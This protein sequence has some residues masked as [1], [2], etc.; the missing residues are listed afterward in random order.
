MNRKNEINNKINEFQKVPLFPNECK[1][2]YMKVDDFKKNQ[3]FCF[4]ITNNIYA[5]GS[6]V[7][8][9]LT[10]FE[11]EWYKGA[12]VIEIY[13]Y[14]TEA[15]QVDVFKKC[16]KELLFP[17]VITK[18]SFF[19][20]GIL[21]PLEYEYSSTTKYGFYKRKFNVKTEKYEKLKDIYSEY[22]LRVK[23]KKDYISLFAITTNIGLFHE[24]Y[25][26]INFQN[27]LIVSGKDMFE[28]FEEFILTI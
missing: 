16:N 11:S 1:K 18:L 17:P 9:A 8:D 24:I 5:Y 25:R 2:N 28:S 4:K 26:S 15:I 10:R 14:F 23:S 22:G 13:N 20:Q 21:I 3:V 6:V 7:N 19:K 27:Q 12:V